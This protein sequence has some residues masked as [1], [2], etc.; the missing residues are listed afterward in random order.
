MEA[1]SSEKLIVCPSFSTCICTGV[2]TPY[3]EHLALDC[4]II[5]QKA[6]TEWWQATVCRF[7]FTDLK[8]PHLGVCWQ[9]YCFPYCTWNWSKG[10]RE[11]VSSPVEAYCAG[12]AKAE[13][14]ASALVYAA[15]KS[16]A[17]A[18]RHEISRWLTHLLFGSCN[19]SPP[20]AGT[21]LTRERNVVWICKICQMFYRSTYLE[22]MF[23]KSH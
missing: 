10:L 1:E 8:I 5:F 19:G 22:K 11:E 17:S 14:V 4:G 20:S 21:E 3:E 6:L 13:V 7:C 16:S 12:A 2:R 15:T 18:S 23:L 9:G